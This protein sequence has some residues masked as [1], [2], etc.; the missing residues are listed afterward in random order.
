MRFIRTHWP[1]LVIT[2]AVTIYILA[3]I[4]RLS[5][6]VIALEIM[7][8]LGLSP[9]HMSLMFAMTMISY[10]V[11][12]P[13]AGFWADRFGPRRCLLA[14]AVV[15]GLGS[16]IFSR[17]EGLVVGLGIRAVIGAAAGITIL[18][19][20]KLAMQWFNPDRFG[21]V[22]SFIIASAALA[23]FAVGRPLAMGVNALGWRG[24]FFWL[25]VA[26]LILA[27]LAFFIVHDNPPHI[28]EK[29]AAEAKGGQKKKSFFKSVAAIAKLPHFWLLGLLYSCT[30]MPYATIIG[31]WIGPYLMEVH[32]QSEVAVGNM[33]SISAFGFLIGPPLWM[34]VANRLRSLS[35]VVLL[36]II[37]NFLL[38]LFLVFGPGNLS[39]PLLYFLTIVAPVGGQIAGILF[40]LAKNL[41]P[42]DLSAS[43]MG[44]LNTFPFV[45]GAAMQKII[46][47]TLS[48]AEILQPGLAARDYYG[49]AFQPY[50]ICM[51]VGIILALWQLKLEKKEKSSEAG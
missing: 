33:L 41:V 38:G 42:E 37:A 47:G 28:S 16:I 10:A 46:G 11:M 36:V 23:N 22:S 6:P 5:P 35:K 13:V 18:S 39:P 21:L 40:I 48:R 44:L 34:I 20:M 4:Q 43:A 29:N 26:G 25:G 27:L 3:S 12:Q 14:A 49:Q 9:D 2:T 15:L 8:D 24:S 17:A 50:L 30:D 51:A 45:F 31:L 7:A 19:C 32:G 1:L